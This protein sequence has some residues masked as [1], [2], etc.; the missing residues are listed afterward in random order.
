[1]SCKHRAPKVYNPVSTREIVI[2]CTACGEQW[3]NDDKGNRVPWPAVDA[4][5][6]GE[7]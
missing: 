2:T 5:P 3:T 7:T 6:P 1:M 4:K